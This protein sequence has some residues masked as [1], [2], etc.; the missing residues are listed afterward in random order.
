MAGSQKV[1]SATSAASA[2]V[3]VGTNQ[4]RRLVFT[5]ESSIAITLTVDGTT[6]TDRGNDMIYLP[7]AVGSSVAVTVD[8]NTGTGTVSV[9][10]IAASGTPDFT[11]MVSDVHPNRGG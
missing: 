4:K 3:D 10:H 6:A 9:S 5:N 1:T 2:T 11:I 7:A 8:D